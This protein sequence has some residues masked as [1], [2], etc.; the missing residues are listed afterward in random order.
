LAEWLGGRTFSTLHFLTEPAILDGEMRGRVVM[1]A[2]VSGQTVGFLIGS[3]VPA[4][5]GWLVEQIVRRRTAPNGMVETLIDAFMR[6]AGENNP[7]CNYITLGLVAMTSHVQPL[8]DENPLWIRGLSSWGRAHL[9]RFYNFCGL[10]T[11]RTKLRPVYWEPAYLISNETRMSYRS[12]N[13]VGYAF[14][15]GPPLPKIVSAAASAA[16]QEGLWLLHP[17][18]S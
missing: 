15:A 2:R 7:A 13:A 10:E 5:S 8:L 6:W 14:C 3:P 9:C 12:L 11:F 1:R 16:R 17:R 18:K 4:R